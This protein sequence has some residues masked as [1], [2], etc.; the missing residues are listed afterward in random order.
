MTKLTVK[1]LRE[2]AKVAGI[3]GYSRMRKA[4]LEAALSEISE[5]ETAM[6]AETNRDGEMDIYESLGIYVS[7]EEKKDAELCEK[8]NEVSSCETKEAMMTK[9]LSWDS[10]TAIE[11]CYMFFPEE[12][13]QMPELEAEIEEKKCAERV[14][15]ILTDPQKEEVSLE[16]Q[17]PIV[18]VEEMAESETNEAE[19][20]ETEEETREMVRV[21]ADALKAESDEKVRAEMLSSIEDARLI[22]AIAK[23]LY[24][25]DYVRELLVKVLCGPKGLIESEGEEKKAAAKP[26]NVEEFKK[27]FEELERGNE[28]VNIPELRKKLAWDKEE[29]DEMLRG[30][31][32]EEVIRLHVTDLTI[33]EPEEFFYDE[34]DNS[35]MGMVTWKGGNSE[36]IEELSA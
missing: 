9:L 17:M 18:E 6:V 4:E 28:F 1:E 21:V 10:E 15:K 31:R 8:A 32:D 14:W 26:V 13:G 7:D 35:R 19:I 34:L 25:A 3:K 12:R 2:H 22:E 36:M 5:E 29:F 20:S 33:F 23:E 30:L 27:A 16:G 24:G 11:V